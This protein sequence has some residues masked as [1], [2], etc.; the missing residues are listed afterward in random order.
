[1]EANINK[2]FQVLDVGDAGNAVSELSE[3]LWE[4]SYV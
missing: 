4:S 2:C 3:V 1:M